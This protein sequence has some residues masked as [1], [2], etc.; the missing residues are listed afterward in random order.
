MGKGKSEHLHGAL[1]LLILRSLAVNSMHG[2][3]ISKYIQQ[4]SEGLRLEERGWIESEWGLAPTGRRAKVYNL[5]RVGKRQLGKE[6]SEW[7]AFSLAVNRV[8]GQA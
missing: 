2:W 1:E 7:S 8:L 4:V 6:E 5:T 3:G